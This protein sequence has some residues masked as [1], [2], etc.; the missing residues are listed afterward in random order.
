MNLYIKNILF[1]LFT[2]RSFFEQGIKIYVEI[3]PFSF[4]PSWIL[5]LKLEA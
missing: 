5:W 1:H 3:R 4:A 2:P